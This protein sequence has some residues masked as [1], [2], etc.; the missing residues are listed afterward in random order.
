MDVNR[1][2]AGPLRGLGDSSSA[3][4]AEKSDTPTADHKSGDRLARPT[5]VAVVAEACP[6]RVWL[7]G[8]AIA[9]TAV[10]L[11]ASGESH[12]QVPPP[13]E[14]Q[15]GISPDRVP[16]LD[17]PAPEP[18]VSAP[19]QVDPDIPP[20][21]DATR[22]FLADII[23]EGSTI[24]DV[25]DL[26]PIYADLLQSQ[27]SLADLYGIASA[28]ETR[29]RD[30]GFVI[31]RAIVPAQS[32]ADGVYRIQ[33]IEGFITNV[34]LEGDVGASRGLIESYLANITAERPVNIADIERYL[35]LMNDLPGISGTGVL[36]PS[37]A[38][39]GAAEL[40]VTAQ[41]KSYDAFALW[42]NRG[43][44]FTGEQGL[45]LGAAANS[46]SPFGEQTELVLFSALDDKEQ[47]V[48]QI[49]YEQ[50]IGSDGLKLRGVASYGDS[51]PG[52]SLESLDVDQE[53]LFFSVAAEYPYV[54]TR[55]L[56]FSV[57]AGLD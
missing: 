50:Q 32:V 44:E 17:A 29:Y 2:G 33:V 28:I 52:G 22:F 3:G 43:S 42:D 51:E 49:S 45:A 8:L 38:D 56:N 24:Y 31:S 57:Q 19:T 9:V 55:R 37:N 46:F 7:A 34:V 18:D 35:L 36:R 12:A 47:R 48:A 10:L 1:H 53:T 13:A 27:I 23:V 11:T 41:R 6:S 16:T 21:A 20:G 39:V 4:W 30:D 5:A 25:G 14:L 54:R 26:R 15:P 40:I